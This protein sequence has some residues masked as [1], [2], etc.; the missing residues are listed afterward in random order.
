M[1]SKLAFTIGGQQVIFEAHEIIA[2]CQQAVAR[3]KQ[4]KTYIPQDSHFD[5]FINNRISHQDLDD[6]DIINGAL[7]RYLTHPLKIS[8]VD[9]IGK[10][11]YVAH[12]LRKNQLYAPLF[13]WWMSV[14][15]RLLLIKNRYHGYNLDIL[16]ETDNPIEIKKSW[17]KNKN[18]NEHFLLYKHQEKWLV[19][20]NDY[21]EKIT[22]Q[23]ITAQVDRIAPGLCMENFALYESDLL[24]LVIGAKHGLGHHQYFYI[25]DHG[26][27]HD[28]IKKTKEIVFD[29]MNWVDPEM[30][31]MI[32]TSEKMFN[33]MSP[34]QL[35]AAATT[36][37]KDIANAPIEE[38]RAYHPDHSDAELHAMRQQFIDDEHIAQEQINEL[39][40]DSHYILQTLAK[41]YCSLMFKETPGFQINIFKDHG[42][43]RGSE[44]IKR[45]VMIA[46]MGEINRGKHAPL[47]R[48]TYSYGSQYKG[49]TYHRFAE[50]IQHYLNRNDALSPAELAASMRN[51]LQG[52]II[53]DDELAFLP[54]LTTAWFTAEAIRN[55]VSMLS[56]LM[57]L[58]M[59]EQNV[60]LI[61]QQGYNWYTWPHTLIHPEKNHGGKSAIDFYGK[62]NGI[63]RFGGAQSMVHGGSVSDAFT[64]LYSCQLRLIDGDI[65]EQYI[66]RVKQGSLVVIKKFDEDFYLYCTTDREPLKS[67]RITDQEMLNRL[68]KKKFSGEL[69]EPKNLKHPLIKI[70]KQAR[71]RVHFDSVKLPT[72]QQ[73]DASTVIHWLT[74]KL[75]QTHPDVTVT[76]IAAHSAQGKLKTPH[77]FDALV[78]ENGCCSKLSWLDNKIKRTKSNIRRRSK[79]EADEKLNKEKELLVD[80]QQQRRILKL[81]MTIQQDTIEPLLN[82]RLASLDNLLL[83]VAKPM[84]ELPK[85]KDL[86][87][88]H[89]TLFSIKPKRSASATSVAYKKTGPKR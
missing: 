26:F 62:D 34:N 43:D 82:A 73:K 77:S 78:D 88:L 17:R 7:D 48:P 69:I 58:D 71:S 3:A 46:L 54:N 10:W 49:D 40:Q 36:L 66:E 89:S 11:L 25:S 59:L 86:S 53:I 31:K 63:D 12:T 13:G 74:L 2:L 51:I 30:A 21:R 64:P 28:I 9:S 67:I 84:D 22:E 80:Y 50:T 52:E 16:I 35:K 6:N 5:Q 24:D 87:T 44:L 68:N 8:Q 38:M 15:G 85:V 42:F 72:A 1:F 57:L 20:G 47:I 81:K 83:S 39:R 75:T 23:D 56:T 45:I 27:I 65:P 41:K 60:T 33:K 55:H 19:Y 18:L 4:E 76:G 37:A 61:N 32:I 14:G 79:K 29:G 70:F